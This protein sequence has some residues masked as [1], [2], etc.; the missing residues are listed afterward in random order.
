[1]SLLLEMGT[2]P[3]GLRVKTHL[4][5]GNQWIAFGEYKVSLRDFLCAV[6]YVLENEDLVETDPRRTFLDA[7]KTASKTEGWNQGRERIVFEGRGK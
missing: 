2:V 6:E 3:H 5:F 7:C 1:M 4:G